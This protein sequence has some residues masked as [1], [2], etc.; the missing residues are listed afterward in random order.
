MTQW[1]FQGQSWLLMLTTSNG[2]GT[3]LPAVASLSLLPP[4][5]NTL[6]SLSH[7][8]NLFTFT[9][10]KLVV[11]IFDSLNNLGQWPP[12][13]LLP[14]PCNTNPWPH[15]MLQI[16]LTFTLSC[17]HTFAFSHFCIFGSFHFQYISLSDLPTFISSIEQLCG[18]SRPWTHRRSKIG[19]IGRYFFLSTLFLNHNPPPQKFNL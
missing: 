5:Y 9:Q 4:L 11:Q 17:F 16:D 6:D 15:S 10:K 12:Q 13:V 19:V 2:H 14:S 1:H 18:T 7:F 8:S 3:T